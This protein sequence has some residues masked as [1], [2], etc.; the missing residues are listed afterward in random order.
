[1]SWC[2]CK[3]VAGWTIGGAPPSQDIVRFQW[4][5]R[6]F[7]E[8][9]PNRQCMRE[10]KVWVQGITNS[11]PSSFLLSAGTN[12]RKETVDVHDSEQS[13]T[14]TASRENIIMQ[15]FLL[16]KNCVLESK[17]FPN[18]KE[19]PTKRVAKHP[20]TKRVGDPCPWDT[21]RET[22]GRFQWRDDEWGTTTWVAAKHFSKCCQKKNVQEFP[23]IIGPLQ[24]Y[25]YFP[26]YLHTW[27]Y[28]R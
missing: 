1:M 23:H 28:D 24:T 22:S 10:T 25:D 16:R 5:G 11:T 7:V 2:V 12:C 4:L 27:F 13:Q 20:V 3:K 15:E 17:V 18:K 9:R 8:S 19:Q 14:S 26:R 21:Y 6:R